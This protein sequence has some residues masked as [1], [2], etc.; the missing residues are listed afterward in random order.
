MSP[1]QLNYRVL[2]EVNVM[3]D[4]MESVFVELFF[5]GRQSVFNWGR[6]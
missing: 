6:L 1:T 5:P 3:N 2:N 4:L